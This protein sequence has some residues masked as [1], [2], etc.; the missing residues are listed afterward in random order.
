[1]GLTKGKDRFIFKDHYR[2]FF[3]LSFAELTAEL[4]WY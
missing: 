1:M 3:S 2:Y 4:R